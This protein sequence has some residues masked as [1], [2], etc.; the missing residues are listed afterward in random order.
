MKIRPLREDLREYLKTRRLEKKWEKARDF[1]ERDIGYSSL[2][3]E[4]LE[5]RWR[6]VYSFRLDKKYRALFVITSNEAEI[7]RITNHYKK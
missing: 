4:L 2:E 6:G 7:I 1:F 5:P 3:T